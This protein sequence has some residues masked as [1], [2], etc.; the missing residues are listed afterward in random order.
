MIGIKA[1]HY[2]MYFNYIIYWSR[3]ESRIKFYIKGTMS[4]DDAKSKT[5]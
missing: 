5:L 1:T 2:T 3:D 4:I